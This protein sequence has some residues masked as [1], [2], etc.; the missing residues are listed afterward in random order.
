MLAVDSSGAEQS[1]EGDINVIEM[2]TSMFSKMDSNDLGALKM[3]LENGESGM[4]AYTS[5][6]EYSY[7]VSPQIYRTEGDGIRQVN[8]DRSF[9]ALGLGSS[10]TSS[11]MMATFMGTDVFYEMPENASLYEGQYDVKAGRWPESYNECVLVLTSGGGISDFLLYT[12]GLRDSVELDT[13]VE[14][15]INEE[16]IDTPEDMGAYSYEDILGITFRLVQSS[17]YY[18]YDSRYG[19]WKD[20]R[21]DDDYMRNLVEQGEELTIV[22][23]VQPSADA[24]GALLTTGI[25]YPAS[26][27][28]YVAKKAAESGIVKS[29]LAD[30]TVNVFTGEAFGES[31]QEDFD[32]DSLFS[33][34][35]EALKNAFSVDSEAIAK[36]LREPSTFPALREAWIFPALAAFPMRFPSYPPRIFRICWT[37]FP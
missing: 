3:W 26:L 37:A 31:G 13:M 4:E 10:S 5:A 23:I 32:M 12:L 30:R 15:F 17:D 24:N 16:A 9:E 11:S 29:Q 27:T 21:D 18:Q 20:K 36:V 28:E 35:E 34:D 33:V 6:I 14:Q 8:P 7:D 1:A 25:A 22:G 19:V 2:I